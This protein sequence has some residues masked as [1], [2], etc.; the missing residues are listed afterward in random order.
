MGDLTNN[1]IKGSLGRYEI[2]ERLGSGGMARVYKGYD[3]NLGRHVAI[4]VLHDH[5]ADDPTFKERFEREAKFVASLNHPNIVQVFDYESLQRDGQTI[6]YMV[7]SFIPGPSLRDVLSNLSTT[8]RLLDHNRVKQLMLNLTGAL[9]YAHAQGMVHRDVKPANILLNEHDEAVLTDFGIARLAQG[10]TLTQ[11]GLTVGTPAYM[12]PEQATGDTVDGRTDLY[13]LGI[14]L[15]EMLTGK[16]PFPDD[17]SVSVL[18]KHLNEPVPRLSEYVHIDNP[19]LDAI[20]FRALAKRPEDRYQSALQFADDLKSAFSGRVPDL[21]HTPEFTHTLPSTAPN[22]ALP[23]PSSTKSPAP[24]AWFQSPMG[25]FALGLA[26]ICVVLFAGLWT[27]QNSRASE[28]TADAINNA[29]SMTGALYFDSTFEAD[30]DYNIYWPQ[31]NRLELSRMVTSDGFYEITSALSDAGIATIFEE[32]SVYDNL[33]LQMTA[34]LESDSSGVSAY[35]LIFNYI[36]DANYNVFTVDGRGRFGL[37]VRENNR[38]RELRDLPGEEWTANPAINGM[39]EMNTLTV[40]AMD[41]SITAMVNGETVVSIMDETLMEGGVGI[42]VATPPNGT[43]KVKVD[44]FQVMDALPG[45]AD[46]MTGGS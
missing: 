33:A 11:E 13:A 9:G 31:D 4:K 39:G 43:A 18:L 6:Y 19:Y 27:Q 20:I 2:G 14:I 16:T 10:S 30:D 7:M 29:E 35:G 22:K 36:N 21:T 45:L 32:G 42:Y 28:A 8:G 3:R 46:S 12:S 17:G 34:L 41:G 37:W 24:G 40:A 15:Y 23:A 38:W 25:L 26:F 1:L 5:L 44:M